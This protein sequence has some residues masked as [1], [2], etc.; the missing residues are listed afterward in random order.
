MN[1]KKPLKAIES[2][3]TR[4]I[5][6]SNCS[7]LAYGFSY[8]VSPKNAISKRSRISWL[9]KWFDI[10]I[11]ATLSVQKICLLYDYDGNGL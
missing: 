3:K 9:S 4:N 11:R 8:H 2:E 1:N 6:C 5:I 10:Q 7:N